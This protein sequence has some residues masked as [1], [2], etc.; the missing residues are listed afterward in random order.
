MQGRGSSIN[1]QYNV[2]ITKPGFHD[3]PIPRQRMRSSPSEIPYISPLSENARKE[4]QG[5]ADR[6]S[7]R[8]ISYREQRATTALAL[9][10]SP[11]TEARLPEAAKASGSSPSSSSS[12]PRRGRAHLK[13]PSRT[14]PSNPSMSRSRVR[15][16]IAIL[17]HAATTAFHWVR[18]TRVAETVRIIAIRR[19]G[20]F[21]STPPQVTCAALTAQAILFGLRLLKGANPLKPTM[22]D[23]AHQLTRLLFFVFWGDLTRLLSGTGTARTGNLSPLNAAAVGLTINVLVS[24]TATW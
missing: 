8:P 15:L 6:A 12:P 22:P 5:G 3:D 10:D 4:H 20:S 14:R 19:R 18:A 1:I 16:I 17:L 13:D 7:F 2:K 11:A 21:R 24:C 23:V 9:E